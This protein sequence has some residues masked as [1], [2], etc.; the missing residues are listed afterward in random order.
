MG[1]NSKFLEKYNEAY[2]DLDTMIPAISFYPESEHYFEEVWMPVLDMF[3]PGVL[4]DAYQISNYGRVYTNIKSPLYPNGG[5][6][7]HSIN[8]HGYHQINLM[9]VDH[10]KIGCKIARLVLLHFNFVAGCQYFE[11]DHKNGDKDDNSIWNLEWV[12]PQE[13]V[14]RAIKNNLRPLSCNVESGT[15]LTDDQAVEL[16]NRS[17]TESY[18][19]LA[20]EYKVSEQYVANLHDGIIRPYIRGQYYSRRHI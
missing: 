15:L 9:S 14:H 6:M 17:F 16:F 2:K 13:N 7:V 19:D 20:S 4:P 12:T 3:V 11:V 5:I 10:K 1:I 18:S 8:A